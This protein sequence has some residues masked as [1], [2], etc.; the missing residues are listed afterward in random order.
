[1]FLL[2]GLIALVIAAITI[3]TQTFRAAN[4]NPAET[5]REE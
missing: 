5:L 3:S 1:M 2:G 4:I